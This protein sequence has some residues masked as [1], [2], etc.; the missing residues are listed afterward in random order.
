M[1]AEPLTPEEIEGWRK[2][3]CVADRSVTMSSRLFQRLFTTLDAQ[4]DRL[5]A[6]ERVVEAAERILRWGPGALRSDTE[7][8]FRDLSCTLDALDAL[9]PPPKGEG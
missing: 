1:G 7:D 3:L 4:A 8:L 9:R 5:R 6:A 2:D